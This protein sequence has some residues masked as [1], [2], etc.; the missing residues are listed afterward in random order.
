VLIGTGELTHRGQAPSE[1]TQNAPLVVPAPAPQEERIALEPAVASPARGIIAVR[2]VPSGRA[3]APR[4]QDRRISS[5][6]VTTSPVKTAHRPSESR[7]AD[8][9]QNKQPRRGVLDRLRLG[10]LRKP[11]VAN[12][13]NQPDRRYR[14]A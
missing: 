1:V 14:P 11:F 5:K 12:S 2:D 6:G 10:W 9:A 3:L 7:R 8:A 13:G 4:I